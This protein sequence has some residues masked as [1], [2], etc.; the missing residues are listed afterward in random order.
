VRTV[1]YIDPSFGT[2]Q[3]RVVLTARVGPRRAGT[4]ALTLLRGRVVVAAV[5][6]RRVAAGTAFASRLFRV[7]VRVPRTVRRGRYTLRACVASSC[8]KTPV[9]IVG[10]PKAFDAT[11]TAVMTLTGVDVGQVKFQGS[12]HFARQA[13]TI[14][15]NGVYDV[16]SGAGTFRVTGTTTLC[17]GGGT[18][19]LSGVTSVV[20]PADSPRRGQ[21]HQLT[22]LDARVQRLAG[23]TLD[24]SLPYYYWSDVEDVLVS[25]NLFTATRTC[26]AD[27]PTTRGFNGFTYL[28]MGS[29]PPWIVTGP[30]LAIR[31]GPITAELTGTRVFTGGAI[32]W[33]WDLKPID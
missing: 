32:T 30:E 12:M 3:A 2:P 25:G 11:I 15:G 19:T 27:P 21:A 29:N 5:G 6:H 10:V 14:P 9:T 1:K 28:Q 26:P 7:R 17:S 33:T 23:A 8:K 13:P 22:V 18:G 20:F 31:R 24:P 4:I 16:T